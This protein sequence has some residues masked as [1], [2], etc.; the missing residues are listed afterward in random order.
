VS[1]NHNDLTAFPRGHSHT[2]HLANNPH[3]G[4]ANGTL[5]KVAFVVVTNHTVASQSIL[6][7]D[8]ATTLIIPLTVAAKETLVVEL[9]EVYNGFNINSGS[10]SDNVMSTIVYY[11]D[12]E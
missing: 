8:G 9:G 7:R 5:I 6:L 2:G 1:T 4:A 10:A 12:T 11:D 3:V